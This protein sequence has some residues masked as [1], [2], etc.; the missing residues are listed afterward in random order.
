MTLNAR[1]AVCVATYARPDGLARLLDGLRGQRTDALVR[2]IV[3][4]NDAGGPCRAMSEAQAT[5]F[6]LGLRY[7]VEPQRGITYARNR[8]VAEAGDDVTFLAMLD[9]DEVPEPEW[10]AELLRVQATT[11]ADIVTGPVVPYFASPVPT[12]VRDG[13]FFDRPRHATGRRLPHAHT[14]NVL[15]RRAVFDETG[16]FDNRFALT[17]GEDL[18]F[19]RRAVGRGFS[20]VWADG[21]QVLEWI[22]AS[23]ATLTWLLRRSYRGGTTLGLVDRDRSDVWRARG[24]RVVRG[25]GRLVQGV[26]LTPVAALSPRRSVRLVRAM[27]LIARGAGMIVGAFGGRYEE[28]R[29]T[30]Q[31]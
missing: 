13:R 3:V 22:P 6:P 19:F 4:D 10:L 21:A 5:C 14:H 27:Q 31:V 23:R 30:H 15:A 12:W 29:V 25:L 24:G 20:V 28:Y 1:V 9:D 7:V 16:T 11:G 26:L 18:E 2:V 17:G 8:C